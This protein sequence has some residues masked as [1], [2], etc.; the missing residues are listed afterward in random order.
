M[1]QDLDQNFE[2]DDEPFVIEE[3]IREE[4][5]FIGLKNKGNSNIQ[6]IINNNKQ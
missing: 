1:F 6:F 5:Q 3:R 4:G 2:F